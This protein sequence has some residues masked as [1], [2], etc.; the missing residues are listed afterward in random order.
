M[1]CSGYEVAVQICLFPGLLQVLLHNVVCLNS[2]QPEFIIANDMM[3][4]PCI[5]L[6]CFCR[7]IC[8][9]V[10]GFHAIGIV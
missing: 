1:G 8:Y 3:V 9:V 2:C 7:G 6:P 10:Y 5:G 4:I